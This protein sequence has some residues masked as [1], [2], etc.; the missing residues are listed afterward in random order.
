VG[1]F[2]TFGAADGETNP[3]KY[4][5]SVGIGGKGVVPGRP[6]DTFGIGWA[7]TELSRNFLPFLREQLLLGL[8]REDAVELYYNVSIAPWLEATVDLQVVEPALQRHVGSSGT[9]EN[10][11]TAVVAGLRLRARF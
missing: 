11:G 4:S 8:E 5:Y 7:R 3:V 2:F 9:L 6:R 10:T 1:L